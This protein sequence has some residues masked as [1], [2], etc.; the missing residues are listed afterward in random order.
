MKIDPSLKV[1]PSLNVA[2]AADA[3]QDTTIPIPHDGYPETNTAEITLSCSATDEDDDEITYSWDVEGCDGAECTFSLEAG[4]YT[5]T[6][7]AMDIYVASGMDIYAISN[8]D[9][10]DILVEINYNFL[11]Q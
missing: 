11:I 10:V 5:Y 7:T 3:G 6:C 4:S 1:D 2:P 9:T 8:P